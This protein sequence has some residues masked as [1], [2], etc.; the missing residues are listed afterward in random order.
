[1]ARWPAATLTIWPLALGCCRG[2]GFS[3]TG[4]FLFVEV[5]YHRIQLT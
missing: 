4:F 2:E 3:A 5:L 1:M